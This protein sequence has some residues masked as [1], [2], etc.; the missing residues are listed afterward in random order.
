VRGRE[1][2]YISLVEEKEGGLKNK[3]KDSQGF[4]LMAIAD[5]KNKAGDLFIVRKK[6]RQQMTNIW[7]FYLE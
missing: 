1:R 6:T 7:P 2:A 5:R 4:L 3:V